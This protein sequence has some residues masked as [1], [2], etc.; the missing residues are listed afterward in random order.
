MTRRMMLTLVTTIAMLLATATAHGDSITLRHSVRLHH[1]D[2]AITLGDIA[3]LD[4][5]DARALADVVIAT[6]QSTGEMVEID[7]QQVRSALRE[8]GANLARVDLSGRR[9]LVRPGSSAQT[10]A[11][12]AMQSVS[13][14]THATTEPLA[15]EPDHYPASHLVNEPTVRGAVAQYITSN[16]RM[17]PEHVRLAFAETDGDILA[18]PLSDARFELQ[19]VSSL[20]SDRVRIV[21]RTWNEARMVDER[22]LTVRPTF[23]VPTATLKHQV[24]RGEL[25]TP[26]AITASAQWLPPSQAQLVMTDRDVLGKRAARRLT[27]GTLLRSTDIERPIVVERGGR[28]TVRCLVGG[29][30]I[31]MTA[32]AR[33]EGSVGD[34]ITFRKLG[35]REEFAATIT[36]PGE[37]VVDLRRNG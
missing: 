15:V 16:L 18:Q 9:V 24:P 17:N 11:V 37:A 3:R 22:T 21:I 36:G 12:Q 33:E 13:L 20:A 26:D 28:V 2:A 14:D 6:R 23:H 4:G 27:E 5:A 31:S 32:E 30:A 8:A 35:E 7:L 29:V 34:V 19:P 25:I 10:Q 1:H